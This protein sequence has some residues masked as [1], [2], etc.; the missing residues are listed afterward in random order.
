[1]KELNGHQVVD[2]KLKICVKCRGVFDREYIWRHKRRSES[3][4]SSKQCDR[5]VA[6]Q[7]CLTTDELK[8]GKVA[9]IT[10]S[11]LREGECGNLARSDE[12][13][14]RVG[15]NYFMRSR[16]RPTCCHDSYEKA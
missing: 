8:D 1:M 16:K 11:K 13:I 9:N 14:R 6:I 10:L 4:E 5:S 12:L 2:Q 7:R 15:M 3:T